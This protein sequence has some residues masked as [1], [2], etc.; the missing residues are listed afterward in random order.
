MSAEFDVAVVGGSLAGSAATAALSR[1]GAKVVVLEKARFPRPK[2]CGEFLSPE[3][4][5]VLERA[6]ALNEVHAAGAETIRRFA[7]V[8]PDGKGVEAELPAPVLS[9]SRERLD[10][11]VAAAAERAGARIRFGTAVVSFEGNLRDGFRVRAA[12]TE[13]TTRVLL[14]AWGRYN[15]LDGRLGRPFFGRPAAL[16]GFKKHLTGRHAH[17]AGRA[18]LHLFD[19]GYLGLS[20]VEG[21]AVNLAALATPRVAAEAHHDFDELLARLKRESPSLAADLDGL[22]P[23]PGPVLV[24][25]PVHLGPHGSVAGD[26]LLSGDAAGVVDPYTGTGMALA[27]RTGEAAAAP[28]LD[29]LGGR[30]DAGG[31]RRRHEEVYRTIIG[32]RF[33][34]SRLFRS[35]FYG[36]VLSRVVGTPP[37]APLV[38]WAVRRTRA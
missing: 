2:I 7:L 3:A 19:G 24:S 30:L 34:Y 18:V 38:Q 12:G 13:L 4:L 1:A 29:F 10:S 26:V 36:G 25:E 33:F 28:I 37:A 14:G 5:P 27:L 31:L 9:L 22:S 17:L 20:R 16:F 23:E 11:L 21:G 32:R 6:G 35:V 15:P 8:R